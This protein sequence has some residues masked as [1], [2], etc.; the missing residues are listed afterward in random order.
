MTQK[1]KN[2]MDPFTTPPS[3]T[4]RLPSA[5]DNVLRLSKSAVI[6]LIQKIPF[7]EIYVACSIVD[8]DQDST[9][10]FLEAIG[11]ALL[12]VFISHP[13]AKTSPQKLL[14]SVSFH[15]LRQEQDT[16]TKSRAVETTK[17]GE[18]SLKLRF[19]CLEI[20]PTEGHDFS[21]FDIPASVDAKRWQ[22]LQTIVKDTGQQRNSTF[23]CHVLTRTDPLS[24]PSFVLPQLEWDHPR[25]NF[26]DVSP[27]V[28]EKRR[29]ALEKIDLDRDPYHITRLERKPDRKSQRISQIKLNI[30]M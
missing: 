21:K 29:K 9:P 22:A 13:P 5:S 24:S 28:D 17:F 27:E 19:N 7:D 10:T 1:N 23:K 16:L 4:S 18:I 26:H 11:R 12:D 30:M 3:R 14:S 25:P 6:A 20:T 15:E 8:N 2:D